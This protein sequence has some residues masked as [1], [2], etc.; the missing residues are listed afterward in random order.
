MPERG[1]HHEREQAEL[2]D[3]LDLAPQNRL[4]LA[5]TQ[6]RCAA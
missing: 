5:Q 6:R 1:T 4:V 3:A 2:R